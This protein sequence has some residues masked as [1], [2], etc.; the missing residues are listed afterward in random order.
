MDATIAQALIQVR[1]LEDGR[2]VSINKSSRTPA[3]CVVDVF[4]ISQ[5]CNTLEWLDI[6]I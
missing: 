6:G 4:V 3:T 5:D 1:A 2:T